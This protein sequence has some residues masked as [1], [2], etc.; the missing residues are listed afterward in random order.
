MK[1]TLLVVLILLCDVAFCQSQNTV[2]FN[3]NGTVTVSIQT[4]PVRLL[5]FTDD[6][7]FSSPNV[8]RLHILGK[9]TYTCFCPI[10]KVCFDYDGKHT[11]CFHCSK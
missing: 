6:E 5:L 10:V 7:K 4:I 2:Q 9:Y 1:Y 8:I 3:D 11:E